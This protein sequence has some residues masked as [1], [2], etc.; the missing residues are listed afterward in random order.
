M[1]CLSQDMRDKTTFPGKQ[2][3]IPI[4]SYSINHCPFCNTFFFPCLEQCY[5]IIYWSYTV[6]RQKNRLRCP[7]SNGA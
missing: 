7:E 1:E 5:H 4:T 3:A 2:D 6:P